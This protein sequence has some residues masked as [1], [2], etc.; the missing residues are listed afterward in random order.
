[1]TLKAETI[2]VRL[3]GRSVLEG[4]SVVLEAGR[5]TGI[6]GPNGAGKSTLIKA[7][8]RLLALAAGRVTLDGRDLR[9]LAPRETGRAIAYLPQERLVHWPLAVGAVVALGRLPHGGSARAPAESDR[10]CIMKAMDAMDVT[11]LAD[12]TVGTLSGG[13]LA[14]VLVARALAQEARII[15]ADE[16]TAGLD[17]GHALALFGALRRLA[18]EGRTIA[19]ALH[20]L[21]LAARFCHHVV[22]LEAGRVAAAGPT[23]SVLTAERLTAVFGARMAIGEIAGCPVIVPVAPIGR[24]TS[25]SE[26]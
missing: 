22:V 9:Q 6:V 12:R 8:A 13:E 10:A 21:S 15:L 25:A 26:A 4:A 16:P 18:A 7:L 11:H 3:G 24:G 1:V 14:R 19:V 5:I 17:P 23:G 2:D 20:D